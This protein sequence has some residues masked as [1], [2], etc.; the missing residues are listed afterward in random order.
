M[1]NQCWASPN[2]YSATKFRT[3]FP[4]CKIVSLQ[5]VYRLSS[6]VAHGLHVAQHHRQHSSTIM[7][8]TLLKTWHWLHEGHCGATRHPAA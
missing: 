3:K 1:Y 7:Q 6:L 4:I 2:D 5:A 8:R